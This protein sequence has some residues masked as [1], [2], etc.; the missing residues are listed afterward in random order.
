MSQKGIP[1]AI[2]QIKGA[3]DIHTYRRPVG[4]APTRDYMGSHT[5]AQLGVG[6]V[7]T[8]VIVT[9]QLIMPEALILN[10]IIWRVTVAAVG[11]VCRVG[12]YANKR[13]TLF[14]ETLLVD[15]G[16]LSLAATGTFNQVVDYFLR[17]GQPYW[18]VKRV[19]GGVGW[20][21]LLASAGANP[22][23]GYGTMGAAEDY[24]SDGFEYTKLYDGIFPDPFPDYAS[25]ARCRALDENDPAI[26]LQFLNP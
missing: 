16:E 11:E 8:G 4:V 7:R 12:L 24:P 19:S 1:N 21:A 18:L 26:G 2:S 25:G 23:L 17:G 13:A 15:F 5:S 22:I 3:M 20:M 14:P 10:K 6:Q 9:E